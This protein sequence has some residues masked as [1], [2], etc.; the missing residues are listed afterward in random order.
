M[1]N[2]LF[3]F[4][5]RAGYIPANVFDSL[6]EFKKKNTDFSIEIFITKHAQD[7]TDKI[8]SFVTKHPDGI[9]VVAGGDGSLNEATNAL[10]NLNS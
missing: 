9:I 2:V 4:S 8:F 6:G 5:N 7:L 3:I 1:K 10:V